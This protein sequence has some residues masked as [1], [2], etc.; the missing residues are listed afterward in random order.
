LALAL[1]GQ[2][3]IPDIEGLTIVRPVEGGIT[4]TYTEPCILEIPVDKNGRGVISKDK[5]ILL[6]DDGT[7]PAGTVLYLD[8]SQ[9]V[10]ALLTPEGE[11]YLFQQGTS[12]F[13]R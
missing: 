10:T 11:F 9:A 4:V 7:F 8:D 5:R 12:S 13:C 6:A 1:S 3:H 2:P